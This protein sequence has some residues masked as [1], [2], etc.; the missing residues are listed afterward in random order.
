MKKIYWIVTDGIQ[1][2]PFSLDELKSRTDITPDT[3]VWRE[4][5]S[6]WTT[7]SMLP[8]LSDSA[9]PSTATYSCYPE[10]TAPVQTSVKV[11]GAPRNYLVWAIISTICCCIPTGIVAIFYA[12]KV[13]PAA[14][15]GD[16]E[17]ARKASEKAALW[18]VISFVAGLVWAPFSMLYSLLSM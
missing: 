18:V 6:D 14:M 2:G 12:A 4:G 1:Q 10:K 15:A 8:E 7:V 5:M 13:N 11:E 9:R 16:M 17:A 3:P